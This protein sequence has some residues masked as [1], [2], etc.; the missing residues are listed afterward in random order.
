[1]SINGATK[2]DKEITALVTIDPQPVPEDEIDP[3]EPPEEGKKPPHFL[4]V[5]W[6]RVLHIWPD[7][8]D[9]AE[10]I[11]VSRDLPKEASVLTHKVDIMSCCYDY[12]NQFIFTGG[13]DGTL[14][15]WH[16][17]T[18][19]TKYQLHEED[20]TCVSRDYVKDAKS[21]DCLLIM[22]KERLLLSGSCDG[23]IRVWNLDDL[24]GKRCLLYKFNVFNFDFEREEIVKRVEPITPATHMSKQPSKLS[25]V[26]EEVEK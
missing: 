19:F 22:Q 21:V 17:E 12:K 4:G 14:L 8:R 16:F 26:R 5:G 25:D 6:D 23:F 13:H 7:Q 2:V 18:G 9:D 15:A 20:P 3:T 1:L 24:S 11:N 10:T